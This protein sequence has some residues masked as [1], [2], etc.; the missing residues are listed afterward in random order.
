M[1]II[2][3][4]QREKERRAD[5][6]INTGNLLYTVDGQKMPIAMIYEVSLALARVHISVDE[7]KSERRRRRFTE[8]CPVK[9]VL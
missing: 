4:T 8:I 3:R 6:K 2:V 9:K 1:S 5:K 7:R